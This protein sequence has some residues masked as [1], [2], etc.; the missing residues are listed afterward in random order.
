MRNEHK[1]RAL[2]ECKQRYLSCKCVPRDRKSQFINNM[3]R[4]YE[5]IT[6]PSDTD[7]YNRSQSGYKPVSRI[8]EIVMNAV[9]D[10][11]QHPTTGSPG[12]S[13]EFYRWASV[14]PGI[15][16]VNKKNTNER[17]GHDPTD[18]TCV[19]C[20]A[21]CNALDDTKHDEYYFTG[22]ARS[23]SIRSIEESS[24]G[25]SVDEFFTVAIGGLITVLNNGSKPIKAGSLVEWSFGA[26][27]AAQHAQSRHARR[28]KVEELA[29]GAA[30]Q[31]RVI[32]RA[33]NYASQGQNFDLLIRQ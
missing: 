25:P 28:I 2:R 11:R 15:V 23:K 14:L 3:S 20:I 22:I 32:G 21:S 6:G 19:R 1:H 17:V 26:L 10:P 5:Y 30:N 24:V 16:T 7:N 4:R 31:D 9:V 8:G 12:E 13:V 18:E 27:Q 33:M 29:T